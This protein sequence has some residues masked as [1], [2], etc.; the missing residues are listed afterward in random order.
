MSRPVVQP[1]FPFWVLSLVL[2]ALVAPPFEPLSEVDVKFVTLKVVFL[3]ATTLARRLGELGALMAREPF[4]S[5]SDDGVVLRLDSAF[6]PKVSSQFHRSQELVLP[7]LCAD[8]ESVNDLPWSLLDVYRALHVC[9]DRTHP[10]NKSDS[11]FVSFGVASC[12]GK[13]SSSSIGCWL[14]QVIMLAYSL[15]GPLLQRGFRD[16][17]PRELRLPGLRFGEF[18]CRDL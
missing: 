1:S 2:W 7:A 18:P 12:G 13:A 10:F 8:Q 6:V 14:K 16:M 4:L 17:L 9:L 11:M 3:V 5:F 15:W